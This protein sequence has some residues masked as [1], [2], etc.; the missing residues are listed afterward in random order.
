MN[1]QYYSKWLVAVAYAFLSSLAFNFFWFPG[2]IYAN[3]ITGLSQLMS[4]L[5]GTFYDYEMSIPLLV[6]LF[7]LPLLFIAWFHIDR[8]FTAMTV[9]AVFLTSFMM[10]RLPVVTLTTDPVICAVF[11]GVLHGVSVG[12][13]LNSGFSTGGLDIIG[14]LVRQKTNKSLGTIFIIFN[15]CI[16]FVAGYVYGWP[17]AFYSAISVFISGRVVDYVN[18]RQQKVQVMIVTEKAEALITQMQTHLKRGMTIVNDVEGAFKRE[19][20]KI[21]FVV[22]AKNE[23][24]ALYD[25]IQLSDPDA[26]MSVSPKVI[27]NKVFYEW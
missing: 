21:I 19:E 18:T 27:T 5:A 10:A 2:K 3:G 7:N 6:L 1:R 13:T 20:K 25:D 14:I 26:F 23:L 15:V 12:I 24:T 16:Q 22:I 8:E 9:V 11:G 4:T 17:L